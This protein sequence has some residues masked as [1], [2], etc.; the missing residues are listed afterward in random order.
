MRIMFIFIVHKGNCENCD[1]KFCNWNDHIVN[2]MKIICSDRK[3]ESFRWNLGLQKY[4]FTPS[5]II[6][7]NIFNRMGVEVH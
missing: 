7:E 4:F 2:Y 5:I 3:L 1:L 6:K